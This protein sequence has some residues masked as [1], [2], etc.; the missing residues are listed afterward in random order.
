MLLNRITNCL[1][2]DKTISFWHSF[3]SDVKRTEGTELSYSSKVWFNE[4]EIPFILFLIKR[5]N[6]IAQGE[7]KV[8][9]EDE[10]RTNRPMRLLRDE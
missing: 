6:F 5:K 1:R 10:R 8:V 2:Q 7:C 4:I 3:E 9:Y